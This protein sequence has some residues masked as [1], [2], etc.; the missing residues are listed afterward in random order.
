MAAV[1]AGAGSFSAW[2]RGARAFLRHVVR[3]AQAQGLLRSRSRRALGGTAWSVHD[4]F[5]AIKSK[6]DTS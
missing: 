5:D 6:K 2:P 1:V 4:I 3:Q